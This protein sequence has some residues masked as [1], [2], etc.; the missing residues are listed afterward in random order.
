MECCRNAGV[1]AARA[2]SA[3]DAMLTLRTRPEFGA[4]DGVVVDGSEEITGSDG[5]TGVLLGVAV[6]PLP[7]PA[8]VAALTVVPL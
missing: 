5:T 7:V 8:R 1:S 6:V 2:S 4:D 3:N